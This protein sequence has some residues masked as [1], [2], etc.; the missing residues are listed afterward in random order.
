MLVQI[1]GSTPI[2]S[3][4]S[5]LPAAL[6]LAPSSML[7]ASVPPQAS[8]NMAPPQPAL[9]SGVAGMPPLALSTPA[10]PYNSMAMLQSVAQGGSSLPFGGFG[11]VLG[12]GL[13][14][15][16]ANL[17]SQRLNTGRSDQ[18]RREHANAT[19]PR[20]KPWSAATP[21]PWLSDPQLK[22]EDCMDM[23]ALP[24]GE[25]TQAINLSLQGCLPFQ[26]GMSKR[27]DQGLRPH[28]SAWSSSHQSL[29]VFISNYLTSSTP[30]LFCQLGE[31]K[32]FKAG[33]T[34]QTLLTTHKNEFVVKQAI[35]QRRFLVINFAIKDHHSTV[36]SVRTSLAAFDF[37]S[38]VI[39]RDHNCFSIH[40]YA[41][42]RED[43]NTLLPEGFRDLFLDER[44][45]GNLFDTLC[46]EQ[47]CASVDDEDEATDEQA[48]HDA[49]A[50]PSL[51]AA[52][53]PTMP[54]PQAL[55]AWEPIAGTSGTT[56]SHSIEAPS[57]AI[58]EPSSL[59]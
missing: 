54:Q 22:L 51:P 23:A 24:N 49:L 35:T 37:G 50:P 19:L 41:A 11:N 12:L 13:Q 32:L 17:V 21:K 7:P 53:S 6:S 14:S 48:V 9:T 18:T 56:E 58:W 34:V 16:I 1:M 3:S 40:K 2:S 38:E 45:D 28:K 5:T 26:R 31:I 55:Q 52:C 20:R 8:S 59:A 10:V 27:S 29:V 36:T 4:S 42:F 46:E 25:S 44:P 47:G 30:T 15:G 57:A 33:A 43:H 39:K